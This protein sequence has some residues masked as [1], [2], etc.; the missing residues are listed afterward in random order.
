MGLPGYR[1][2]E[3]ETQLLL[4]QVDRQ[5]RGGVCLEDYEHYTLESLRKQP[6]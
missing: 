3:E 6:Y 2:T 4:Q 1:M 5:G